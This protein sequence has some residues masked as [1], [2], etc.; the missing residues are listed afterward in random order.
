MVTFSI[1]KKRP[2]S[3]IRRRTVAP[4]ATQTHWNDQR[5]KI[6]N[7][8]RASGAQFK[9]TIGAPND[10]Y[11]QEADRV[12]DEVMRMPGPGSG[13]SMIARGAPETRLQRLCPECEQELQRQEVPEEEE[14]EVMGQAKAEPGQVPAVGADTEAG[15][16]SL[17]GGGQS[18]SPG[19]RDYF[20]P[21]FGYDLG[22]VR[23]HVGPGAADVASSVNAKAFTLGRDVVFGANQFSP[24]SDDG[25]RLLAHELT[26]VV[27]QTG[28]TRPGRD[29]QDS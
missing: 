12:A 4:T 28:V 22:D 17:R 18:L 16:E 23:L 29:P 2:A 8:L 27:Q 1:D 3:V 5:S 21:R 25:R 24:D 14:E 19:L 6:S 9:L 7:A 11:E 20:E 26:H 15:I 10:S 13:E